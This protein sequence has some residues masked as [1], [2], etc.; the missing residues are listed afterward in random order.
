MWQM[1][2][3]M[4]GFFKTSNIEIAAISCLNKLKYPETML[5]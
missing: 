2:Y 3:I 5:Q 4:Q 1:L